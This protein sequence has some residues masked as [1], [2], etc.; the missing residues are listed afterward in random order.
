M[1]IQKKK[2][3]AQASAFAT[4]KDNVMKEAVRRG[5]KMTAAASTLLC[6]VLAFLFY[7]FFL[8]DLL[9]T[10]KAFEA[11]VEAKEAENLRGEAIEKSQPLFEEEFRKLI[12]VTSDAEPLLPN[13]TQLSEMLAGVQDIARRNN[14]TLTGLTAVKPSQKATLTYYD[15][16]GEVKTADKLYER[17]IPA[18]VAGNYPNVVRFFYD[19]KILQRIIVVR[20]FALFAKEGNRVAANFTLMIYHAPPPSEMKPLPAF[21]NKTQVAELNR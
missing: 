9:S 4:A 20:D 5:T 3:K 10:K 14:V 18:Q 15:E 7:W 17:E 6:L 11:K 12:K 16:K 1:N 13:E 2:K 21:L 19:L 8:S